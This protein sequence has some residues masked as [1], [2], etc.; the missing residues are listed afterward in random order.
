MLY[1]ILGKRRSIRKFTDQPLERDKM[2]MLLKSA[3]LSPSSRSIRPWEFLL[4]DEKDMLEKLSK[5]K[6]HGASFLK[7]AA[8]GIVVMA[9]TEKS[10]VWVEDAAIASVYLLLMAEELGLGACWVQIRKRN[11]DGGQSAGEYIRKL[12]EIPGRY[13]IE[14][15]I[16]VGYPAENKAAYG[17]KELKYEKLHYLSFGKKYPIQ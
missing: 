16:A 15:V 4:T 11:N 6:P 8:A 7:E 3:L 5:C 12:L 9:D 10:D 14:S 2:D 1:D 17:D 13:E